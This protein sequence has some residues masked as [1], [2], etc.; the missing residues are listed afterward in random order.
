M[1][2]LLGWHNFHHTF[3]WDYRTSESPFYRWNIST[4][5]I[6]FFAWLGWATELKTVT[7]EMIRKRALRTG[8]GSHPY[9]LEQALKETNNNI[10][11]DSTEKEEFLDTEHFWGFGNYF[12]LTN[13]KNEIN[14]II[15]FSGDKEMTA[16]D[17]KYIAIVD[18]NAKKE[19]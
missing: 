3:P 8:D 1:K 7:P 17:M 5:V 6:D 4:A 14:E 12:K 19:S 18:S 10:V 2:K 16:E 11:G 9:A 15:Q 13:F